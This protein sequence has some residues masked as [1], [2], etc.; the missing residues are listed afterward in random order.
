MGMGEP[1]DN[2]REVLESI[3]VLSDP[4]ALGGRPVPLRRI[5]LST[6]G[7]VSGI[8]RLAREF[9]KVQLALSLHAPNDDVRGRIVPTSSAFP[10]PKIMDAVDEYRRAG[11]KGVMIEYIMIEGVNADEKCARE[12]GELLSG[13]KCVVNLIPY[14]PTEAGDRHGYAPPS[15]ETC[16]A[17]ARVLYGYPNDRGRPLRCS[18]R[19]SSRRGQDIDAACGQLALKNL[20][21]VSSGSGGGGGGGGGGCHGGK[22]RSNDLR[23]IEDV[24]SSS[25][26][27]SSNGRGCVVKKGRTAATTTRSD[28][29]GAERKVKA[30]VRDEERKGCIGPPSKRYGSLLLLG[31]ATAVTGGILVA[32]TRRRR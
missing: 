9:P 23:D 30:A 16:E 31:A 19:Y 15:D 20:G 8:R 21:G 1:L 29:G 12:L 17:F 3:R 18:I 24:V 13:T 26:A 27:A 4:H 22:G 25:G 2:C 14:N 6:V 11:G 28:N 7:V 10:I 5:T 32:C